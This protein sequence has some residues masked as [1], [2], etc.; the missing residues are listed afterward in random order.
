MTWFSQ[1]KFM[2][3]ESISTEITRFCI[4]R[5]LHGVNSASVC[6]SGT[7]A[8]WSSAA[9]CEWDRGSTISSTFLSLQH[10]C[11]LHDFQKY[12][13]SLVLSPVS[14]WTQ[15]WRACLILQAFL[16]MEAAERRSGM[17][18]S[19][20]WAGAQQ[21]CQETSQKQGDHPGKC[22]WQHKGKGWEEQRSRA[23][24]RSSLQSLQTRTSGLGLGM[25]LKWMCVLPKLYIPAGEVTALSICHMGDLLRV[26][27]TLTQKWAAQIYPKERCSDPICVQGYHPIP[28]R[29]TQRFAPGMFWKIVNIFT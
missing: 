22:H 24:W 11:S 14:L 10:F 21:G 27:A 2:T 12:T 26:W 23:E 29:Q 20:R 16:C 5:E 3:S 8:P 6:I 25:I 13:L 4:I 15:L 18:G 1:M 7:G 19:W 17:P 28:G 9:K